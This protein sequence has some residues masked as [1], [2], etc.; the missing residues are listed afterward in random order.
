MKKHEGSLP[1][2]NEFGKT[3]LTPHNALGNSSCEIKYDGTRFIWGNDGRL[4]TKT[5]VLEATRKLIGIK[6]HRH[7]ILDWDRK[8][9][10]PK[11]TPRGKYVLYPWDTPFEALASWTLMHGSFSCKPTAVKDYRQKALTTLEEGNPLNLFGCLGTVNLDEDHPDLVTCFIEQTKPGVV[12]NDPALVLAYYWLRYKILS[13]QGFDPVDNG[14]IICLVKK[15]GYLP[16]ERHC[17]MAKIY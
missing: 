10:I 7:T 9:L 2:K 13:V 4:I 8:G 3:D 11:G 15:A 14:K 12:V 1:L 17:Y 16:D 5:D 6:I